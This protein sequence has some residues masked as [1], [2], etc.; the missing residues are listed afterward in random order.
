MYTTEVLY[1]FQFELL[2]ERNTLLRSSPMKSSEMLARDLVDIFV[3]HSGL[4]HD[5]ID[6][7]C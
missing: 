5:V 6:T 1:C 3:T 4:V 2:L 7:N